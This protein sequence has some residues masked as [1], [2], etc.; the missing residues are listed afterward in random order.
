LDDAKTLKLPLSAELLDAALARAEQEGLSHLHFLE[1]ILGEP[2][3]RSRQRAIERRIHD[4]RFHEDKNLADFNWQF[5]AQAIDRAQIEQLATGEF[6]RRGENLVM[7]GQS[8]V[9]KSFLLQAISKRFCELGYRVR[10]TTSAGLLEDLRKALAEQNLPR[11]VRY[12]S[13]FDMVVIDEFG[14]DRI[15]RGECPQAA[16]L[17]YKVIDARS[18]RRST[19]L[20][21]NID[22]EAWSDYLG[23]PPLAM[24]FLDRVVDGAIL[25]KIRGKSYR[26]HRA[27]KASGPPKPDNT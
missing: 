8:G 26:A 9:G 1:L 19:A 13:R 7:V 16:N 14:F 3:A 6:V 23:D 15:E 27:K 10:Y 11:R 24:A 25:L 12:W 21:T 18:G 4:A 5:N 20:A 2:A 17:F 22:F